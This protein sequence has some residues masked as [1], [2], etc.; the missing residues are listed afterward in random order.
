[1]ARTVRQAIMPV[2]LAR[3]AQAILQKYNIRHAEGTFQVDKPNAP[4]SWD[5]YF[6]HTFFSEPQRLRGCCAVIEM[7]M[8]YAP[9]PRDRF[10][11]DITP[12][13]WITLFR[14]NVRD[15]LKRKNRRMALVT[16]DNTQISFVP[17]LEAAGFTIVST[18][19]NP[20]TRHTVTIWV[21]NISM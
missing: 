10:P 1:M 2:G 18:G 4:D 21:L 9:P 8:C 12:E 15:I 11:V 13:E 5:R 6:N 19:Y 3:A 16:L 20:G 17:F 7:F 14:W